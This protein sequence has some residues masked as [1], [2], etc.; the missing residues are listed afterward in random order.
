MSSETV[1]AY[2][3]D[4]EMGGDDDVVDN[5]FVRLEIMAKERGLTLNRAKF[6]IIGLSGDCKNA[7][8]SRNIVLPE[9][10]MNSAVMLGAPLLP[11]AQLKNVLNHTLEELK[12]LTERLT[13]MPANDALMPSAA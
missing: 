1:V 5:D 4:I 10:D 7:F 12:R 8:H 2:L 3:D 11:G 13:L 9:T 6:E